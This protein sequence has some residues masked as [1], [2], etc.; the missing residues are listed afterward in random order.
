MTS[1]KLVLRVPDMTC[2]HCV[3]TVTKAAQ[4]VPGV[5]SARDDLA[6]KTLTIDGAVARD[7]VARAVEA[8]GYAVEA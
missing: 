7:A 2:G 3:Q 8:A 4:A 5:Q 6:S 1:S